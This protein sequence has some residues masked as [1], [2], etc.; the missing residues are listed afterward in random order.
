MEKR[1]FKLNGHSTSISLELEFWEALQTIA[2]KQGVSVKQLIEQID[3][4]RIKDSQY[5]S[6]S[7]KLRVFILLTAFQKN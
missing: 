2:S 4:Q 3:G 1:S 6:L 5:S 7:S